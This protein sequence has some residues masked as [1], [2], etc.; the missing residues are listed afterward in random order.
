MALK[1]ND[2]Q[3]VTVRLDGGKPS[4]AVAAK[5]D[6][7]T[8][9]PNGEAVSAVFDIPSSP[10]FN[11]VRRALQVIDRVH[12]NGDLER[13]TVQRKRLSAAT[14][15]GYDPS[16]KSIVFASRI[17]I[18]LSDVIHEAFH[19]LDD[20]AF[21]IGVKSSQ[22]GSWSVLAGV[23][24]KIKGSRLWTV[25]RATKFEGLRTVIRDQLRVILFPESLADIAYINSDEEWLARAYVQYIAVR[26]GDAELL[27][28]VG[29]LHSTA[30]Y[31]RSYDEAWSD[32][33]FKPIAEMFDRVLQDRRWVL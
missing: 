18:R 23:L 4:D 32:L 29:D 19:V 7:A 8:F 1:E 11:A 22:Q 30:T 26:S 28:Q 12:G 16:T 6:F 5:A 27:Q 13:V 10:A 21:E 14:R 9:Q 24:N 33:E 17:D 31:Q 20:L 3:F 25:T 2:D 15:A